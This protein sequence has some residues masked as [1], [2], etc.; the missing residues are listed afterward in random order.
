[1]NAG[2]PRG[3]KVTNNS[4]QHSKS[5][6]GG[7]LMYRAGASL[8][9]RLRAMGLGG[10]GELGRYAASV[11]VTTLG[12]HATGFLI[13]VWLFGLRPWQWP[14]EGILAYLAIVTATGV[15]MGIG[16]VDSEA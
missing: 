2:C 12:A 15:R 9:H 1:M 3:P 4:E 7:S 11:C 8:N 6:L 14:L 16:A 5:Q 13:V 10:V